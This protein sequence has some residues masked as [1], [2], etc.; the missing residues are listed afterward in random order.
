MIVSLPL[1][2]R[3]LAGQLVLGCA[4]FVQQSIECFG[5]ELL[6]CRQRA[7]HIDQKQSHAEN[8]CQ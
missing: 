1:F 4:D 6:A 8:L 2:R 3:Q 7:K 5:R